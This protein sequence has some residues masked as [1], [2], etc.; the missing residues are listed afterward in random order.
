MKPIYSDW[1]YYSFG[2]NTTKTVTYIS[3]STHM[4]I[5][6]DL[7]KRLYKGNDLFYNWME[8]NVYKLFD[9]IQKH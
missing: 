5:I 4:I 2:N 1:F 6:V 3:Y 9:L 7:Y 8:N